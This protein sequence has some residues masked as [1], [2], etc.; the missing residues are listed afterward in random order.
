MVL[1]VT[2]KCSTGCF[3]C[4]VS[5]EKKGKNVVYAN[6]RKVTEMSEIIDEAKL[7][8]ATG[9]GITGGDPLADLDR[10]VRVIEKLKKTFGKNHHIHLYT[11]TIDIEKTKILMKSGLDEIR[12]HP[13][14]K[15]WEKLDETELPEIAK[16]DLDVGMEV[17]S[18]PDCGKEMDSLLAFAE[19]SKI[20]FVNLNELEFSESNWDMMKS[21]NYEIRDDITAAVKGSRELALKMIK[22]HEKL[23]IHFCPSNFKDSVQLRNRFARRAKN[24]AEKYD[25]I[26]EDGTLLRGIA[27]PENVSEAVKILKEKYNVPDKLF[28]VDGKKISVAPWVLEEIAGELPF[29]CYVVEIYPTADAMEVERIPLN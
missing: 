27:Y 1:F 29:K 20:K 8:S 22:K 2:G 23:R 12:F 10:T 3:Y 17:P 7:M 13:P 26:T 21:R 19:N 9:T 25:V 5:F 11:S 18:L 15:L 28:S 4:P 6:E 16:L 14:L 24:V